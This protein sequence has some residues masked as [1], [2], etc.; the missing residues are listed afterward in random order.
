MD[1][2]VGILLGLG[3]AASCGFRVFVP[4]LVSSTASL[5]G[6][7]KFSG[8]YEW[9]GSWPAF[10]VFAS[11]TV[12]EIGAYYIPLIDNI[13]DTIAIPL[14]AIGGTLLSL[15]FIAD[16]NPMVQWT[17]SI[18]IGG[19]TAALIKTG[20]SAARLKS[21]VFSAGFANWI[22]ATIE[23]I[24]SFVFSILTVLIPVVMGIFALGI[25]SFFSYKL[26]NRKRRI[27]KNE[28]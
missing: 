24:T 12:I 18:I 17:L 25:L 2:A 6:Y 5:M 13:L 20:A 27:Q 11:A 22:V 1:Y 8:G 19:G 23:N 3:L 10:V 28:K 7:I 26:L 15:S 14:A 4:L 16:M 21:T 9:M